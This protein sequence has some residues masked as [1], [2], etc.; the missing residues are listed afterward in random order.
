M[1]VFLTASA[2]FSCVCCTIL[3]CEFEPC[4][5]FCPAAFSRPTP[6]ATNDDLALTYYQ[7]HQFSLSQPPQGSH[8]PNQPRLNT[9]YNEGVTLRQPAAAS[10]TANS[11]SGFNRFSYGDFGAS[12]HFQTANNPAEGVGTEGNN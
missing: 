8:R 10:Q 1:W 2:H 4:G 6:N 3:T 7:Q 5:A 11:R 12:A 9:S